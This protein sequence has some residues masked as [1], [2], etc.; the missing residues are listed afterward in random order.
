M[1]YTFPNATTQG[2]RGGRLCELIWIILHKGDRY[3]G[4]GPE[5]RREDKIAYRVPPCY[6]Q[7]PA[8]PMQPNN[9][10]ALTA[11][12]E[13]TADSTGDDINNQSAAARPTI[14]PN[15]RP[16]ALRKDVRKREGSNPGGILSVV[17]A[18]LVPAPSVCQL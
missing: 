11:S 10:L 4:R 6:I 9:T 8:N 1:N 12:V 17:A 16:H 13:R 3:E 15:F 7:Q 14:G 2:S 18:I 5:R